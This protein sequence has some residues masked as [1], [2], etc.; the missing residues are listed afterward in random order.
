V[1]LRGGGDGGERER[2]RVLKVCGGECVGG[3]VC[4]VGLHVCEVGLHVCVY[5]LVFHVCALCE[6]YI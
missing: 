4:E 5:A 6:S 1:E 2:G 3:Y